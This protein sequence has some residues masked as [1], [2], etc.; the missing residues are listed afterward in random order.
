MTGLPS[1]S[2]LALTMIRYKFLLNDK[3]YHWLKK[4][5]FQNIWM[6]SEEVLKRNYYSSISNL[7]R[8]KYEEKLKKT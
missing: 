2:Q 4:H 5:N 6:T 1:M 7:K 8:E 3:V